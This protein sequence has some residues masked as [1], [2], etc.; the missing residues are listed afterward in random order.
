MGV[1]PAAGAGVIKCTPWEIVKEQLNL[2][3]ILLVH[4]SWL[5]K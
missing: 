1:K 2:I 5:Y 4:I 3:R